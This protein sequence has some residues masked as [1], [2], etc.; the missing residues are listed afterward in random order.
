M[1]V[2]ELLF[3]CLCV[4]VRAAFAVV[5]PLSV[6]SLAS[7]S[8]VSS[9]ELPEIVHSVILG[10]IEFPAGIPTSGNGC[11]SKSFVR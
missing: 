9:E 4:C 1:K 3:V 7:P 11:V 5:F 6:L 8:F 10:L 2:R